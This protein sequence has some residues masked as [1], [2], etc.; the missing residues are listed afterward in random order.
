MNR[1][2]RSRAKRSD[3]IFSP[4]RGAGARDNAD[5]VPI[6]ERVTG[7]VDVFGY[8]SAAGGWLFI[9]WIRRPFRTDQP[10]F[11]E[12]LVQFE[13]SQC[14]GSATLTFYQREDLDH[15]GIGVI[16]FASGSSRVA[17]DLQ[18]I[19]FSLDGANYEAQAG[20]GSVRLPDPEIVD[21]VRPA[22]VNQA[23]ANRNRDHLLAV[24]SRAGFTGQ[25]TLSALSE[26]VLLEIDEAILCPPAGVLLKGWQLSVQ[27]AIR[28]LS[29]RSGPLAGE[30]NLSDSICIARPD[31]IAA[32]GQQLGF[33]DVRCGFVAYVAAAVSNGDVS[34][35]EVELENGEVGFKN[36]KMSKRSGMDAIKR[37]LEGI[38]VRY[39]EIDHAY[40]KV[41]GPAISSLNVAQR[42]RPALPYAMQFGDI[43]S[44][45]RYSLI[46]PLYGR[47][48]FVEY[49][50]ALFSRHSGIKEIE[51]IYV[52]DDPSKRR[53]LEMLAHSTYERFGI[54][55]HLLLLPSNL[56]FGP[57]SNV[58]LRHARGDFICFLNSDIFPITDNWMEGLV[59]RLQQNPKIGVIGPRLLYEDG[60]IQHEGCFYRPIQEFG[61]WTFVD[62]HNKGRF[63][64]ESRSL[65][66]CDAI[67]GACMVMRRELALE[68]GGF[69]EAFI[70][71]DFEDSDLCMKLRERGLS[72]AIAD[73]FQL[74]HLERK[75]QAAPNQSWRMNLTL[76]NAW[77]HQ[78]RWFRTAMPGRNT[79]ADLK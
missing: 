13:Q 54:P 40:D 26:P 30:L 19:S 51:I 60:S 48:D 38:D 50:M 58:G 71:G 39:G 5:A 62:H 70:V 76:Y 64:T 21:R 31:V 57:A 66:Y 75:S 25:D 32:V 11:V 77:L 49:Q 7:Y 16:A 8:S 44:S 27:G 37:I 28:A 47:I 24:T 2:K 35:I 46:I 1:S 53:E 34:Y 14:K 36:F 17:G 61:N 79:R 78:R 10:E 55:F 45:P 67:T 69:D 4:E 74:Y 3:A 41:L 56:G 68:L 72:C 9:G 12:C 23:F 29:V 18:F 6:F 73:D 43:P 15:T 59:E 65:R 42:Q 33:S 63:P 20:H 22:L 52:L